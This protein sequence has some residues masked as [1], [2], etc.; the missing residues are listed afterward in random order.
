MQT[1]LSYSLWNQNCIDWG[2]LYNEDFD[3]EKMKCNGF[4]SNVYKK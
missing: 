1:L 4:V 3:I 2:L